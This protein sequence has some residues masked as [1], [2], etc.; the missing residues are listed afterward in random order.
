MKRRRFFWS[1]ERTHCKLFGTRRTAFITLNELVGGKRAWAVLTPGR[2]KIST[3]AWRPDTKVRRGAGYMLI[4]LTT[5]VDISAQDRSS[6]GRALLAPAPRI[7]NVTV[8][9]RCQARP[10]LSKIALCHYLGPRIVF[11][12]RITKL[13]LRFQ[14]L[15]RLA[16]AV[17]MENFCRL[18]EE[19]RFR[20]RE[21]TGFRTRASCVYI[22]HPHRISRTNR[23]RVAV[24]SAP[25]SPWPSNL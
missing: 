3:F 6:V 9:A 4:L 19:I 13:T 14:E 10:S 8:K 21:N 22:S 23:R 5:I 25:F 2:V 18:P 1:T 24:P 20:L 16:F 15:I 7:L 11:K 17:V 12:R